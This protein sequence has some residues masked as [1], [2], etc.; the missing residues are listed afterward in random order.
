MKTPIGMG[1][2]VRDKISGFE[3]IVT[4]RYE[5]FNGCIR[6]EVQPKVKKKNEKI[7]G[8]VFDHQQLEVL[9]RK[10]VQPPFNDEVEESPRKVATGGPQSSAPVKRASR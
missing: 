9:E 6:M 4:A 2:R 1:D 10:A 3:G 5:F 8:Q 7:E